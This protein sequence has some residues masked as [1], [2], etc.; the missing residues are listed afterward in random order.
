MFPC[1]SLHPSHPRL[2]QLCPEVC[3]LCLSLYSCL[4]NRF[5]STVLL[6]SI[7]MF[8]SFWFTPPCITGCRFIH[9][10]GTD[11]NSKQCV[12][13]WMCLIWEDRVRFCGPQ[14]VVGGLWAGGRKAAA[15]EGRGLWRG[16]AL[17][18]TIS[19]LLAAGLFCVWS[20]GHSGRSKCVPFSIP[21]PAASGSSTVL[22][23][24][25]TWGL[26][27]KRLGNCQTVTSTT[28]E[29]SWMWCQG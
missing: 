5:I 14:A 11:S 8:F 28:W 4:A 1:C 29:L 6:D 24:I 27:W 19:L 17:R 26:A 18:K 25:S 9:L 21:F 23:Q 20:P 12:L 7:Y 15:V 10:T 3:S 16:G 13:S 2:P 22:R